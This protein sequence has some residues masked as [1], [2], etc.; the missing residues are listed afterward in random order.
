MHELHAG[1]AGADHDEVLGQLGRRVGVAGGEH[2]VAV[3]RRPVGDARP[4]AGATA[5][6]TSASSSLDAVGGLD[7]D[8][9]RARS[10]GRCPAIRLHALALEQAG[11]RCSQLLLD[12]R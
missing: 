4:A 1:D 6:M 5:A 10:G 9:V 7:H 8:L 12:R 3:D 2:P 11:D